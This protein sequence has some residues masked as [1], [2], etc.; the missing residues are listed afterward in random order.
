MTALFRS[1]LAAAATM[2]TRKHHA[3]SRKVNLCA[4]F[5][6][7]PEAELQDLPIVQWQLLTFLDFI[8]FPEHLSVNLDSNGLSRR[9]IQSPPHVCSEAE[10]EGPMSKRCTSLKPAMHSNSAARTGPSLVPLW[11]P[12]SVSSCEAAFLADAMANLDEY[13]R[14]QN[15]L[16]IIPGTR[17]RQA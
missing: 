1:L 3:V 4:F 15:E 8:L 6:I 11:L 13:G 5:S 17:P 10:P 7:F 12:S 9:S 14:Q 16:V 2:Y